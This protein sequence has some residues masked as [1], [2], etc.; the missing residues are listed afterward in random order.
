MRTVD[1]HVCWIVVLQAHQVVVRCGGKDVR[2]LSDDT[3]LRTRNQELT[4]HA[5]LQSHH[6]AT[7]DTWWYGIHLNR[8]HHRACVLDEFG[9]AHCKH[10]QTYAYSDYQEVKEYTQ[11][12]A[13]NRWHVQRQISAT[14]AP[15]SQYA[16]HSWN[17]TGNCQKQARLIRVDEVALW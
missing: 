17:I 6:C 7:S 3:V 16:L 11:V 4:H 5:H 15:A 2:R 8:A 1:D 9:W 10:G 12:S 13:R 14:T